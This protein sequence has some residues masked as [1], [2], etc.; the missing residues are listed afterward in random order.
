MVRRIII[1]TDKN[2]YEMDRIINIKSKLLNNFYSYIIGQVY[3]I[4]TK[5]R[6]Y[7]KIINCFNEFNDGFIIKC[8]SKERRSY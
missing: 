3:L 2:K 7:E 8:M 5:G 6:I 1:D 4:Y